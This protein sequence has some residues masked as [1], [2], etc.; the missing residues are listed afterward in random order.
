M[1]EASVIG[2]LEELKESLHLESEK[3]SNGD[4]IVSGEQGLFSLF[5]VVHFVC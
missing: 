2:A 5:I 4:V 3:D 1:E